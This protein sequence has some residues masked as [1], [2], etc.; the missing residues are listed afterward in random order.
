M[1]KTL[2]LIFLTI[3]ISIVF[4]S[5]SENQ[6][7]SGQQ[8]TNGQDTY[9]QNPNSQDTNDYD[10]NDITPIIIGNI[11]SCKNYGINTV[12]I[13]SVQV[14][15][16]IGRSIVGT[17]F[18][19]ITYIDTNGKKC[20]LVFLTSDGKSV[21]LQI[22]NIRKIDEKQI[23]FNYISIYLVSELD[24]AYIISTTSFNKNATVLLNMLDGKI[25]DLTPYN[26][27][28]IFIDND[29]IYC[30]GKTDNTLYKISKN[31]TSFATPLNNANFTPINKDWPIIKLETKIITGNIALDINGIIPPKE[32]NGPSIYKLIGN[33]QYYNIFINELYRNTVIAPEN[34]HA[35]Y[36]RKLFIDN[37]GDL[38]IYQFYK[39][40]D[41]YTT[42]YLFA[43]CKLHIDDDANIT[44]TDYTEIELPFSFNQTTAAYNVK[45]FS[46][47]EKIHSYYIDNIFYTVKININGIGIS[48]EY[49]TTSSTIPSNGT[50]I[51]EYIYYQDN[52][53]IR[54]L[55]LVSGGVDTLLYSDSNMLTNSL[56]VIN[57]KLIFHKYIN[58]TTVNT[59]YLSIDSLSSEP[60]LFSENKVEI[61]NIIELEL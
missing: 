39:G 14:G 8:D 2:L 4:L 13:E 12:F 61:K 32:I 19:T 40:F 38:W 37:L 57:R 48:S 5:C 31:N 9:G 54:R 24:D 55:H 44:Y 22:N 58:A 16:N 36:A 52:K 17:S 51:D 18:E 27:D 33:S 43:K 42:K 47:N 46:L 10:T 45:I 1:K 30:S 23:L 41:N 25:Y 56:V 53:S 35:G 29:N 26:T 15:N 28:N 21:V 34:Y 3:I 49:F 60:Q 6:I 11:Q 50:Y 7:M 59:Y 20:P